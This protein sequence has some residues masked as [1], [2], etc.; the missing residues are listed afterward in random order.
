MSLKT[1]DEQEQP[2]HISS[3]TTE[4]L[5][6]NLEKH[7]QIATSLTN[8]VDQ[9]LLINEEQ[10]PIIFHPTAIQKNHSTKGLQK[11]RLRA[12]KR[13]AKVHTIIKKW[14]EDIPKL[15]VLYKE[16]G[17]LGFQYQQYKETLEASIANN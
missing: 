9:W 4:Q 16:I 8:T 14:K 10:V 12:K 2:H 5:E 17:R 1:E 11:I 15:L 3:A 6:L 7:K 13:V